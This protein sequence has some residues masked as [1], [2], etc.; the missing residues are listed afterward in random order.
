MFAC[1]AAAPRAPGEGHA[2]DTLAPLASS[3]EPQVWSDVS[4]NQ[5]LAPLH[6]S[7]KALSLQTLHDPAPRVSA[8]T[9][10]TGHARA[11]STSLNTVFCC[12]SAFYI[13]SIKPS[14][15]T[16]SKGTERAENRSAMP[17]T[18][19]SP[20][21][22]SPF[23]PAAPAVAPS[24]GPRSPPPGKSPRSPCRCRRRVLRRRGCLSAFRVIP[25]GYNTRAAWG[26]VTNRQR[27][28]QSAKLYAAQKSSSKPHVQH[29]H[30]KSKLF[31]LQRPVCTTAALIH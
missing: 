19:A 15:S 1:R 25:P 30:E 26:P 5:H 16:S 6:C 24:R 4:E 31:Q 12:R 7:S 22:T 9:G 27:L 8:G 10:Q 17:R 29:L 20:G 18:A 2:W 3:P 11:A 14:S 28:E 13:Q 21:T 23:P